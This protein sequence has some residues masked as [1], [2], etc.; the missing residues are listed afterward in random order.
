MATLR[1]LSDPER[2]L[3]P[4]YFSLF[5]VAIILGCPEAAVRRLVV[6]RAIPARRIGA[7]VLVPIDEFETLLKRLP[8]AAGGA[9][10]EE[11]PEDIGD[12]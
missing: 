3:R 9:R 7:R 2:P 8:P 12:P 10:D 11:M 4:L 5:E 6:Q 1:E